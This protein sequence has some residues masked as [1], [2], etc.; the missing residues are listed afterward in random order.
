M[1]KQVDYLII[2]QGLAGSLLA[3]ELIQR[4]CKIH[5]VD[6]Q[7]E[8]ASQVAAGLINPVTGMRLVKNEQIEIL[9]PCAQQLYQSLSSFFKK[10]F[11]QETPLLRIIH[12]NKEL[13]K[14][15]KRLLDPSYLGFLN[16]KLQ[17]SPLELIAPLGLIQQ[18]Q[19]GILSTVPLLKQ[20]KD[21]FQNQQ[22]YQAASFAY[23]D[24][25]LD[26][27]LSWQDIQA[28]KIIF[29]EGYQAINNPWFQYLPFQPVKGEILT[30]NSDTRIIPQMLNYGRWY[31]PLSENKFRIGATF[32]NKTLNTLPSESAKNDLSTALHKIYPAMK[33]A[34][35]FKHQANIR[36]TTLDKYPLIGQHPEQKDILI[37]NGFGSKGSLQIPFYSQHFADYLLKNTLIDNHVNISRVQ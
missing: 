37:F 9:L 16:T 13:K 12:N 35:L 20:L 28:K 8:N 2:G 27:K 21:F 15:Q 3:W 25:R 36:P 34:K 7:T 6:N 10:N 19:T 18:K 29:C 24:L 33:S 11:Y 26:D 5:I 30:F 14:Y 31:I 1:P 17:A 4:G 23:Q 22:Y 32:D